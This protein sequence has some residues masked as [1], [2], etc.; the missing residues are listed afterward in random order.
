MNVAT[1]ERTEIA[2]AMRGSVERS[3]LT[4]ADFAR[5]MGTSAARLSTYL[6]GKTIPS[7]A[8]YLR[9]LRLGNALEFARKHG[10]MTPDDAADAVNRALAEGDEDFAIRMILQAR[11]DLRASTNE[12][13]EVRPAWD[14]RAKHIDD[15]RFDTLF[16]AIIAHEFGEQVPAW[17]ADAQLAEDWVVE[18]PFRS[19]E[20]IRA[21]TPRWLARAHIYIAERG[22]TTA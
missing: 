10:F 12:S 7:A 16:R 17:A 18:D 11:D 3:A 9:A 20:A 4:Q 2:A 19:P 22:L 5:H 6:S 14:R 13:S 8:I 1:D 15:D 21:Q